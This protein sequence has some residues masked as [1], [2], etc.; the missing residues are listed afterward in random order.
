MA[1]TLMVSIKV[2]D[3]SKWKEAFDGAAAMRSNMGIVAKGIY[4]SVEDENSL[5]ILSEYPNL[6]AA[7][8]ILANPAW[9]EAQRKSG[10]TG[11]FEAKFFN[12]LK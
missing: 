10:V 8:N 3:F 1:V 6:E 11:G 9:E 4:Q 7:Q 5:T 12:E 2:A